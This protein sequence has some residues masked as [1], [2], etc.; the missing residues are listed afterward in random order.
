M[1]FNENNFTYNIFRDQQNSGLSGE[2]LLAQGK[3]GKYIVKHTDPIDP[4]NEYIRNCL[5]VTVGILSIR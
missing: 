4:A 3:D 1:L 5:P 2:L